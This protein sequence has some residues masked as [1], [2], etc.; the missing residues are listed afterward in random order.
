MSCPSL[1]T[2]YDLTNYLFDYLGENAT[3]T[4]RRDCKRAILTAYREI[5]MSARWSYYLERL[6]LNTVAPLIGDGS[7]ISMAYDHTGG[8][9]ERQVTI[10]GAIW[11]IW[12]GN[13]VLVIPVVQPTPPQLN[14]STPSGSIIYQVAARVSDTV[15]QLTIQSN[16]GKDLAAGTPFTLYQDAYTLPSDFMATEEVINTNHFLRL[17]YEHPRVWLSR[18]RIIH[19]VAAPRIYTIFGDPHTFGGLTIRFFPAPDQ[20]YALDAIYQRRPR[21][22]VVEKADTGLATITSNSTAVNG[23]GTAFTSQ[24]VGSVMRFGTDGQNEPTDVA[25]AS[26]AILERVITNFNSPTSVTIDRV[27]IDTLTNVKYNVSDPVDIE[28]GAMLNALLRCIEKQTA[29][30]R[31]MRNEKDAFAAYKEALI[32]AR[33]Q[34][35]RS[36]Q[37]RSPGAH[38]DFYRLRDFPRGSDVS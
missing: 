34:D 10:T 4:A 8:M 12:A 11:P 32:L 37:R 33:E 31:I 23:N 16:P 35:A 3:D 20:A 29:I 13:G 14:T 7:V 38:A 25:G 26:P 5:S 19:T 36:F 6:R 17:W 15:L 22:L 9:V 28:P 21:P 2:F 24:M 18:Q 30:T 27:A 1:T